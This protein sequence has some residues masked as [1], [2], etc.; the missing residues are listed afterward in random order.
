M[1]IAYF[2]SQCATS[3][4]KREYDI[5]YHHTCQGKVEVQVIHTFERKLKESDTDKPEGIPVA[6]QVV[7][8]SPRLWYVRNAT[9]SAAS[10]ASDAC[11]V[12]A[13]APHVN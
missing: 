11:N 5:K 2:P 10:D 13:P 4:T 3:V 8:S 1:F 12:G 9:V 7:L 6:I